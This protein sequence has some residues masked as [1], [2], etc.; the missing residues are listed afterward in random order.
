MTCPYFAFPNVQETVGG[1]TVQTQDARGPHSDWDNA[2]SARFLAMLLDF[3]LLSISE[4]RG[5]PWCWSCCCQQFVPERLQ[6]GISVRPSFSAFVALVAI[7][8][9]PRL[10]T[11]GLH[12]YLKG[13]D[14]C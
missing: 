12:L 2:D 9:L 3:G 13:Y 5:R 8:G 14:E 10:P 4:T 11:L 1:H 6:P 7:E